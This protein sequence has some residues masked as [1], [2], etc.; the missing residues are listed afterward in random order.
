MHVKSVPGNCKVRELRENLGLGRT[1][2]G[3]KIGC[4]YQQI[5]RIEDGTVS[6]SDE[7]I[8]KICSE[9]GVSEE[10][11]VGE[12]TETQQLEDRGELQRRRMRLAYE[13]SGLT[14]REFAEKTHTA[15]SMLGDVLAGKRQLTI[16]YAKKIEEA[17]DVG[18]DW[19]LYGDEDAKEC[20]LSDEMTSY[21]KKHPELRKE[22]REKMEAD[23]EMHN[24]GTGT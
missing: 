17:L 11:F 6:I 2:F 7:I 21:I 13:E 4:S 18:A 8:R 16:R 14:Q 10:W 1:V 12:R 24:N 15:T 22:I 19:L 20:P 9:Y 3:A 5:Q 23:R